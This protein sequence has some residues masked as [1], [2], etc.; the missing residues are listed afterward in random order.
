MFSNQIMDGRSFIM[1]YFFCFYNSKY[2]EHYS[3]LTI[4]FPTFVFIYFFNLR[5]DKKNSARPPQ[6]K[7]PKH[8]TT[9]RSIVVTLS[10]T[11]QRTTGKMHC[12]ISFSA[13][14]RI[15]GWVGIVISPMYGSSWT[16][17]AT[18]ALTCMEGRVCQP[19]AYKPRDS[20]RKKYS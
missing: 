6:T 10:V 18:W 14:Y 7:R 1:C 13:H 4:F 17:F 3:L 5:I 15:T 20:L 8:S 2:I 16:C 9:C 11:A 12:N 19:H